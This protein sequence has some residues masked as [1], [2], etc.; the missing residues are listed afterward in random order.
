M[1]LQA[2]AQENGIGR[3]ASKS[4][5]AVAGGSRGGF[6]GLSRS[7]KR[8]GGGRR[9]EQVRVGCVRG[10]RNDQEKGEEG[11]GCGLKGEGDVYDKG[12]K[13]GGRRQAKEKAGEGG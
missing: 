11:E 2:S 5:M 10:D 13:G 8:M 7:E 3:W 4:A 6:R 12:R 1:E 9:R